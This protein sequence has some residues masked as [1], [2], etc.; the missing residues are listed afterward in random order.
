MALQPNIQLTGNKYTLHITLNAL[1]SNVS[2]FTAV[3]PI[4][5][6]LLDLVLLQP[7][8]E[9]QRRHPEVD[10]LTFSTSCISFSGK[11]IDQRSPGPH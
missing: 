1:P 11:I 10:E 8:V 2:H 3:P 9:G 4:P 6:F 7:V 5:P